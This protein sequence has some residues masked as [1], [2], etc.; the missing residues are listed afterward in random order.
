M[1]LVLC[2]SMA[3][4][5]ASAFAQPPDTL[6]TRTYGGSGMARLALNDVQQISDGGYLAA[7][8][9]CEWLNHSNFYYDFYVLRT[10]SMGNVVW[11]AS[12]SYGAAYAVLPTRDDGVMAVGEYVPLGGL[13]GFQST[14]AKYS[15]TGSLQWLYTYPP[16][17]VY[18]ITSVAR[19]VRQTP[20]GGYIVAAT[21]NSN[22]IRW[23]SSGSILWTRDVEPD[24]YRLFVLDDG[25][26][27]LGLNSEFFSLSLM[28]F[29][30]NGDSLWRRDFGMEYYGVPQLVMTEDH[31][32]LLACAIWNGFHIIKTDS[33][34]HE[35]WTR[36]HNASMLG[37]PTSVAQTRDGGYM[38]SL[39][40]NRFFRI[41]AVGD[42]L[43]GGAINSGFGTAECIRLTTDDGYI[44]AGSLPDN[45]DSNHMCLTK[46]ARDP[47]SA[48]EKPKAV[49]RDFSL[50]A[51]PNPFNPSTTLSFTLPHAERAR[52]AVYDVLGREVK[53][54]QE[55]MLTAG[56]HK[57]NFDG[58]NLPAGIYFARLQSGTQSQTQK[59][60]LLK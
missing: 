12:H 8:M 32:F 37:W 30:A 41:N 36:F 4:V 45:Y 42:F 26:I 24:L 33:S 60:L 22:L 53:V 31:G 49:A 59:L 14:L 17:S 15:S 58:S 11:Q 44:V 25:C 1:K 54:L 13:E 50:T 7:G 48:P 51:F 21:G 3:L 27:A 52:L 20:D 23:D 39:E 43:W 9:C 16:D 46:L 35:L 40:T 18:E 28:R 2:F 29:N 5:A 55:G 56:E 38:V 19:D 34:G 57:L 10:D 47:L 6:W